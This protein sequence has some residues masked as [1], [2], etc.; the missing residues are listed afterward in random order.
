MKDITF[1]FLCFR[2]RGAFWYSKYSGMLFVIDTFKSLLRTHLTSLG[3]IRNAVYPNLQVLFWGWHPSVSL[4]HTIKGKP[5][6]CRLQVTCSVATPKSQ[7][8]RAAFHLRS[9]C[10]GCQGEM[11]VLTTVEGAFQAVKL[12]ALEV[13]SNR[14]VNEVKE[15]QYLS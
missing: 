9:I 6:V 14:D 12:I 2:Y 8:T 5:S 4:L 15:F 11:P 10:G 13:L 1:L 3:K 7:H